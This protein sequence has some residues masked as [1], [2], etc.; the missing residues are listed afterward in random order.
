MTL[1]ELPLPI[2]DEQGKCIAL[3][4]TPQLA[5]RLAELHSQ[6]GTDLAVPYPRMLADGRLMLCGDILTMV[7]PGGFLHE[8]W[9]HA[10]MEVLLPSVEVLPWEEAVALLSPGLQPEAPPAP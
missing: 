10:D 2:T 3:V 5:A 6:Y 4:F 1:A 9:I 8:M 7:E